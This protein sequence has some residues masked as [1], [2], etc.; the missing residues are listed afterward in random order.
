MNV[1]FDMR[2]LTSIALSEHFDGFVQRKV[3]EGKYQNADEVISAGLQLLE[4]EEKKNQALR[5]AIQDGIDS[6]VVVNFSPTMHLRELKKLKSLN[7]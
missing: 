4:Q 7:E 3:A 5:K 2:K 6:Q 1:I